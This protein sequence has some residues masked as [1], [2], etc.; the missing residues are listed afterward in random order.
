MPQDR[1]E[2][3][4][5][6]QSTQR[7]LWSTVPQEWFWRAGAGVCLVLALLFTALALLSSVWWGLLSFV[8]LSATIVC[9]VRSEP[10][11]IPAPPSRT[12]APAPPPEPPRE[13][14][15]PRPASAGLT[16]QDVM[17]PNP[18]A[19]RADAPVTAAARAMRDLDIGA[20]VVVEEDQ[21]L[22][23]VTDRDIVV[24]ALARTSATG[25]ATV[26]D[27]CS[28]PLATVPA[29]MSVED[30]LDVMAE[31][32]VRR[33]PVTVSRSVVGMVSMD[34]LVGTSARLDG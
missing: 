1:S 31:K 17:T 26:G 19:M 5:P 28:R 9:L 30:A 10:E 22:G 6:R 2:V 21:P 7:P 8:L 33:L 34:D 20:V 27:V 32:S 25:P 13:E 16:V 29:G 4:R 23:I 12:R 14:P 24:R 15:R 11:E 18:T 3:G